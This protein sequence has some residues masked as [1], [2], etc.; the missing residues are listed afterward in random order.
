MPVMLPIL[1]AQEKK[2]LERYASSMNLSSRGLLGLFL[3]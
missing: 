1:D 3:V 2:H